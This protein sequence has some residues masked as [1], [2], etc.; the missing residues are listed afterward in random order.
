MTTEESYLLRFNSLT[1]AGRGF[2]FPCDRDGVVAL[3]NLS[4]RGRTNYYFAHAL[5][6]RD[7]AYPVV[8]CNDR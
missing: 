6:G 7:Y 4:E 3:D 2:V 8:L 5:I 1:D